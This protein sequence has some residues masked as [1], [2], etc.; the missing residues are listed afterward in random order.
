MQTLKKLFAS[1]QCLREATPIELL[2]QLETR[3]DLKTKLR[4]G[5]SDPR[6]E[7]TLDLRP[8]DHAKAIDPGREARSSV[9]TNQLFQR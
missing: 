9:I 2:H 5:V 3:S 6:A 1:L 7:T 8:L 4:L